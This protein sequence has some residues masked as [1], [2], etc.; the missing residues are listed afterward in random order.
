MCTDPRR[1][2]PPH[3]VGEVPLSGAWV[4]AEVGDD[5][6]LRWQRQRCQCNGR[7]EKLAHGG[8]PPGLFSG[9]AIIA[10]ISRTCHNDLVHAVA[11]ADVER[12]LADGAAR[13]DGL[14]RARLRQRN[15]GRGRLLDRRLDVLAPDRD[16]AHRDDAR[17]QF[18]WLGRGSASA[19]AAAPAP[20]APRR[21]ARAAP[22]PAWPGAASP[23][24]SAARR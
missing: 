23:A 24:P 3:R 16:G 2:R 21:S 10:G 15:L 17:S 11:L 9:N 19:A 14:N 8:D 5:G 13:L 7:G 20:S 1:Q 6:G 18:L 22:C 4:D 12:G